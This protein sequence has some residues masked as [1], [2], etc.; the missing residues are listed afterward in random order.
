MKKAIKKNKD[1]LFLVGLS[2]TIIISLMA[3]IAFNPRPEPKK[4]K[5]I[6]TRVEYKVTSYSESIRMNGDV[7][8]QDTTINYVDSSGTNYSVTVTNEIRTTFG[9]FGKLLSKD[10]QQL[11]VGTNDPSYAQLVAGNYIA[12]AKYIDQTQADSRLIVEID[13]ESGI[14]NFTLILKE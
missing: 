8:N 7:E 11:F 6:E 9:N 1:V 5:A 10:S 12:Y 3:F 2:M 13:T 4:I 14:K